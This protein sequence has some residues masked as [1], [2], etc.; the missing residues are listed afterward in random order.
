[1]NRAE[2]IL[3]NTF[4]FNCFWPLQEQIIKHILM[5]KDALVVMPTGGGK[6]LCYQIP[7]K[8]FDGL[9]IVVTPLISLMKDQVDQLTEYGVPSL[10]LN[11]SLD[12]DSYRRNVKK[13]R[14]NRVKLLYISP[15]T[16]LSQKTRGMLADLPV[17]CI[18]IDEAHCISEWGHDFRPEYRQLADVR[19][20]FP[21]SCCVALTA[22]ATPR[23]REDICR[24]LNIDGQNE[25][26]G[27]FDRPNLFL[28]VIPKT[29]GIEQVLALIEQYPNE[30]GI[31]Y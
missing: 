4:G 9:T 13:L 25:Y 2:F 24:S 6:S 20:L 12:A 18:A 31:I 26:I 21:K 10:F 17:D 30:A 27:S 23:V 5:K 15:E 19:S 16:L 7:S 14:G 28:E 29:D 1:M 8:I 11:S 3:K 22:T